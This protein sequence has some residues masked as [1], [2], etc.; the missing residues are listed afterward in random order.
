MQ[1][2][3]HALTPT[4]SERELSVRWSGRAVEHLEKPDEEAIAAHYRDR[5]QR[6]K[7]DDKKDKQPGFFATLRFLF[8]SQRHENL[9]PKLALILDQ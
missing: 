3:V 9:L 5:Q 1:S 6:K 2:F 8:F 7:A 4:G